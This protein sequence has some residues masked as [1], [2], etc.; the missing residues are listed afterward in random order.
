MAS[1]SAK[2]MQQLSPDVAVVGLTVIVY[3]FLFLQR[4]YRSSLKLAEACLV[5]TETGGRVLASATTEEPRVVWKPASFTYPNIV[6]LPDELR[7]LEPRPYRPFKAGPYHITMGIRPMEWDNW[8]E[9]DNQFPTFHRIRANRIATRGHKLIRVLPDRPGVVKGGAEAARELVYELAEFLS[10]RYPAVYSV[11]RHV[12][13]STP[14][15]VS[16]EDGWKGEGRIR[17]VTIV[18]LGVKYDLDVEDPL[19]VAALLI[20]DDLAVMIEGEDGSYYF[21]AGAIIVP[22]SWRL[23][24]KIGMPLDEIHFSGNVPFY[25]EKLQL[26]MNRFFRRL[27]LE[28]PVVRNNWLIQVLDPALQKADGERADAADPEEL[29]WSATT[30]GPEDAYSHPQSS[31]ALSLSSSVSPPPFPTPPPSPPLPA[32]LP[33]APPPTPATLR[34]RTE[35]QTLRRLPHSGAIVFTIRT[36]LVPI[37]QLGKE[38]GVPGRLAAAI[39]GVGGEI[40]R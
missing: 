7:A 24:D 29:A 10:R 17:D 11:T 22:G 30:H 3:V 25:K 14:V 2:F 1:I 8:I 33:R 39:R 32:E 18:P 36:Y 5:E 12:P 40:R 34:L 13:S 28:A 19:K 37:E 27:P 26:S 4:R 23:E 20:Q 15:M 31:Y 38:K 16:F 6:P 21:Q 9:L 35:R